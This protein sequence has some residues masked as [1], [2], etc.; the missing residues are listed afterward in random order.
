MK[1]STHPYFPSARH[2][3]SGR[4]CPRT[5]LNFKPDAEGLH[6]PASH[7]NAALVVLA[8][9][10]LGLVDGEAVPGREGIAG[11]AQDRPAS[12]PHQRDARLQCWVS[13]QTGQQRVLT[14]QHRHFLS[15]DPPG[16]SRVWGA[17]R[18]RVTKT[19]PSARLTDRSLDI[20][21]GEAQR[22]CSFA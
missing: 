5:F 15:Q 9:N 13:E 10:E 7:P 17:W 3:L 4:P 6:H 21:D 11:L 14:L 19:P 16:P 1:Q 18:Y 2:Q 12:H 22:C 8:L 20:G